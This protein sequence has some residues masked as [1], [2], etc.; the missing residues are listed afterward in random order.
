MKTRIKQPL[1]R[2]RYSA[3]QDSKEGNLLLTNETLNIQTY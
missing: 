1:W 3:E 2:L